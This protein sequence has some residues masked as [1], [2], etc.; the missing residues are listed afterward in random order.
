M[1]AVRGHPSRPAIIQLVARTTLLV[2]NGAVRLAG[3]LNAAL[4][5]RRQS[6]NERRGISVAR[7]LDIAI[8]LSDVPPNA[9]AKCSGKNPLANPPNAETSGPMT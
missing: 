5:G 9:C 2:P 8:G 3:W 1:L 6:A 7:P 4:L